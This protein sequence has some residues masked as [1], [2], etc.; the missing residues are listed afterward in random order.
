MSLTAY[1]TLKNASSRFELGVPDQQVTI[2][3]VL[4]VGKQNDPCGEQARAYLAQTF[5]E[6]TAVLGRRGDPL[7]SE[8]QD[9]RGDMIVS[10]LS[11]WIIPSPV[12]KQASVAAINFHPG[13]PDYPGIGCTNFAIYREEKVFG[14]TCHHMDP[15]VDT[16]SIIAV[17]RFPLLPSDSVYSLT[18]RCYAEILALSYDIFGRLALGQS[19]PESDEKWTRK[20][21]RRSQLNALCRIEPD[22]DFSEVRRRVRATTFPGAP[23][24]YVEIAGIRFKYSPD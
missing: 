21:Y 9:W 11:P 1:R 16:G 3:S 20:P 14:V 5:P 13:P 8:V 2:R 19:L 10:Y 22:M 24:A 12:L 17:R 18:Q 6:V 7:P 4:F 23:G 15:T